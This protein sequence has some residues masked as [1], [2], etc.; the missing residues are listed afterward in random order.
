MAPS[1]RQ[2]VTAGAV[3]AETYEVTR[4][5]GEGG[6]GAVWEARHLRLERKKVAIK[7]LHGFVAGDGEAVGRFQREANIASRLGHPNIIQVHDF[8]TLPG[9][10]PYLVLEYL[11]GESLNERLRRG[12]LPLPQVLA[13]ARQIGSALQAAHN[14]GIVH[15]DLKPHN[16][17]LC[18]SETHGYATEQVKVLDFGIS[19][20]QGS[21]TV[22][23]QTNAILGTP[24]YMSPEQ[25]KGA[26]RDMDHRTDVFALGAMVYEMLTGR[27]AFLGDSI[28][29]VMFKVVYEEPPP[30]AELV[31]GLP[32]N[33]IAAVQHALVKNRDQRCESAA[34]FV[35]ELTGD[36]LN[37]LRGGPA[38][39]TVHSPMLSKSLAA[40]AASRNQS[41][42]APGAR[43]ASPEAFAATMA[44]GAGHEAN[45]AFG[46]T[47]ASISDSGSASGNASGGASGGQATHVPLM[48]AT[49]A[50]SHAGYAP[51]HASRPLAQPYMASPA[52]LGQLPGHPYDTAPIVDRPRHVPPRRALR[53]AVAGAA[54]I[55]SVAVVFVV[56]RTLR[57]DG[58]STAGTGGSTGALTQPAASAGD[59]PAA[60]GPAGTTPAQT[61]QTAAAS[62]TTSGA[63]SGTT[64]GT[65]GTPAAGNDTDTVPDRVK[66]D[67][68]TGHKRDPDERPSGSVEDLPAEL[69][70]QLEDA[71]ANEHKDSGIALKHARYVLGKLQ[72]EQPRHPAISRAAAV[73]TRIYCERGNL[74]DA[75]AS[76]A[77]I[78]GRLKD[79][80]EKHCEDKN[81]NVAGK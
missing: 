35:E 9:G 20:I 11:D 72:N 49:A 34:A 39:A 42:S 13:F 46:A 80:V 53:F 66:P 36:P 64:S 47:M 44:T 61:G 5:L 48:A 43:A 58:D 41:A 25:A 71:E 14:E 27:A 12:P 69:K 67:A 23:T 8:N 76:F 56:V 7:V 77:R 19:K 33:V 28:P 45:A 21:E 51:Q 73:M 26:H 70:K 22:K 62:G 3:L 52:M 38:T 50:Q 78:R 2:A 6:M 17:F 16:V 65:A 63:T 24:Q 74:G 31:P 55:A 15:R 18:P 54:L 4:L 81:V 68:T 30:L 1:A 32:P 60:T 79:R 75:K 37:T 10:A 59:Q 57:N 40:A 29:E